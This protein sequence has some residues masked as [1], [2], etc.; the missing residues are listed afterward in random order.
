MFGNLH[1]CLFLAIPDFT[2]FAAQVART[3]NVFHLSTNALS[4][5]KSHILR[6]SVA[7]TILLVPSWSTN[8]AGSIFMSKGLVSRAFFKAFSSQAL[9]TYTK[10]VLKT[11]SNL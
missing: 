6:A 9:A 1:T 8:M 5:L 10:E 3:I 7:V 11:F 2:Q 4:V